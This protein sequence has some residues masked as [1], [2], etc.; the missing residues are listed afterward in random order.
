MGA[1]PTRLF[2]SLFLCLRTVSSLPAMVFVGEKE[3]QCF[4]KSAEGLD[5]LVVKVFVFKGGSLDIGLTVRVNVFLAVRL[6]SVRFSQHSHQLL[7]DDMN[8]LPE[9]ISTVYFVFGALPHRPIL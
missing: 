3:Q 7:Q 2:L 1:S 6:A 4:Y 5:E 9:R 8:P